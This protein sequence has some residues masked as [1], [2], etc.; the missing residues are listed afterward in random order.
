MLHPLLLATRERVLAGLLAS[1][2]R[3]AETIG[4]VDTLNT[5]SRVDVLDESDLVA[6]SGTLA[7][8]DGAVSEEELPDL[9]SHCQHCA[10]H[11]IHS[12]TTHSEPAITILGDNLLLVRH[13]VS[14]PSP[15]SRGV[16]H[17]N[18]IH[19]LDL[20]T[21]TLELINEETK[22]SGSISTREYVLVHEK[23]P[24][25]VLVLPALSQPSDLQEED[26]VVIKHIVNL[27]E[28]SSKVSHTDVLG[29]FQA[30]DLVVS[31]RWDGDIAVVHA[32]DTRLLLGNTSL[33]EAAV[34]PGS[35]VATKSHTGGLS[36]V[37]DGSELGEGTPATANIQHALTLFQANL[38]ADNGELVILKLLERLL[39]VDVGND[40][41]SVDHTRTQEPA[42]KVITTVVVVT[43]LLL[44]LRTSVHDNLRHHASQE[45]PEEGK[46]EAEVGPV[47]TVLHRFET[48]ALEVDIPSKVH[49]ME[50]LH[51]DS[52]LA[53]VLALVGLVLEF[54]VVLDGS[55]R[56]ASLFVDAWGHAGCDGPEG[57]QDGD[58]GED[59]EEE[60]DEEAAIDLVGEV[61][62]HGGEEGEEDDIAEA[63]GTGTIGGKGRVLDRWVLFVVY[64]IRLPSKWL[65]EDA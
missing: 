29:H 41:R 33:A 65:S 32:Q 43:N 36:A 7:G 12:S 6:S 50:S 54:E 51:G 9:E 20:K 27:L 15:E 21:S 60:P 38:L 35:L 46:S 63:L 11:S 23:T 48:V 55:T 5:V 24:D 2:Q 22:R 64:I 61:G 19:S 47:V 17:T 28:E 3:T 16:V 25:E 56:E 57:H 58:R 10:I 13:P 26:T 59:G 14:V 52:V 42:V 44:V 40:T 8:N 4:V 49:L 18:G 45:E 34:T 53:T 30:G 39:L 1:L 62:G 37:V 31:T